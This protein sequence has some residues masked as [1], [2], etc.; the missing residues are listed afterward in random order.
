MPTA[1]DSDRTPPYVPPPGGGRRRL[2]P[3]GDRPLAAGQVIVV[4]AIALLLAAL[5]NAETIRDTFDRMPQT[6]SVR[7]VGLRLANPLYDVSRAL[8]FDRPGE[9]V[10]AL[11]GSDQGGSGTFA[12]LPTTTTTAPADPASTTT[13]GRVRA[14]PGGDARDDAARRDHGP[15]ARRPAHGRQ[16]GRAVHRRG[17]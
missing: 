13:G 8:R 7:S 2:L 10:D 11:R 15:A 1:R 3:N 6:S 16:P 5:L 14:G 9:R 17:L 12:A 4:G